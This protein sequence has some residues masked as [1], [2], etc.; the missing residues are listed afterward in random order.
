MKPDGTDFSIFANGIRNTVGFDWHPVT[1]E[2]WFTDNGRDNM[3]DDLPPDELNRA[4]TAGQHFGFPFC[5]GGDS[6]DPQFG[7]QRTC[8]E[9][10]P[11]VR[12]LGA[13]VA[14]LGMKF[15]NGSMFPP[16]YRHRIF[17]AEHGSWN[18]SKKAGYRIMMVDLSGEAPTYSV[19]AEGW[20]QNETAWGRPVDIIMTSDG[21]L[22]VSDDLAGAVYRIEYTPATN[23]GSVVKDRSDN[24]EN[25]FFFTPGMPSNRMRFDILGKI[26]TVGKPS[27]PM[28]LIDPA[29]GKGNRLITRNAAVVEFGTVSK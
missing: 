8:S 29:A 13:H 11:P 10:T 25:T 16:E 2:L 23:I 28:L 18:R 14:A 5:H 3:G 4:A 20:M 15:Y 6:P 26:Y 21:A 7:T 12:K 27:T 22:L 24:G 19:F 17:I 9:F 1:G